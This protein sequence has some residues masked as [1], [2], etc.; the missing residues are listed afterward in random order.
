MVR[1]LANFVIFLLIWCFAGMGTVHFFFPELWKSEEVR[2]AVPW[3]MLIGY[4]VGYFGT[5]AA[6]AITKTGRFKQ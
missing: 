3:V 5:I 6:D 1:Y 4:A 2:E